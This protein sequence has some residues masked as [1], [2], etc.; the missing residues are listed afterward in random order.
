MFPPVVGGP[1]TPTASTRSRDGKTWEVNWMNE[2]TRT[3][4]TKICDGVDPST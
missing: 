3:D 1:T 4:P 2:L